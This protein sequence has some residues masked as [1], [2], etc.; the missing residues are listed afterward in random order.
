[1]RIGLIVYGSLM[2]VSGGYLYDR[3]LVNYLRRQ[4]HRVEVLDLPAR[5]YSRRLPDN[6][7]ARAR[8]FILRQDL[9]VVLQDELCH[10]SLVFLNRRTAKH[11][12]SPQVAIVHHLFSREPRWRWL[13]RLAGGLEKRYLASVDGWICNSTTTRDTVRET[14]PRDTPQVVALPGGD[15]LGN[16]P[17]RSM[18]EHRARRRGPLRLVFVGSLIPR[19]GLLALIQDLDATDH[20][21]WHLSVLGSQT[22]DPR[23]VARIKEQIRQRGLG[24]KID[25]LGVCPDQALA[26][27]LA[28]SHLLTMPYAYEGFGIALLEA[29]AFGLPVVGS[30]RGAAGEMIRAGINGYLVAPG[31][32]SALKSI[33]DEL[34]ADRQRLAQMSLAARQH[35]DRHPTWS[36]SMARIEGFLVKLAG[37]V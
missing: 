11:R 31:R 26:G 37:K 5:S 24:R 7:S 21:K 23:Y 27:I 4:G 15:H 10:P 16:L 1:V 18:I 33:V 9:D 35:F 19:K 34:C 17:D 3:Q 36:Q 12:R 29:M 20:A 25:L 14:L 30:A 32:R 28:N 22:A 8:R 2:T 13:N 6:F